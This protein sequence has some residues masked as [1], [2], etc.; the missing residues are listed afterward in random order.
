MKNEAEQGAWVWVSIGSNQDRDRSIRGA[1][2]S[3]RRR[4]GE[5]SLSRVYESNAV[6]FE[7][8][9]FFNLVVGFRTEEPVADL[10]AAFREIE[11]AF[12]R[13]RGAE[14]FCSRTL[15]ID[16]LTYGG[17]TGTLDGCSLP[18][19]EILR[20]AFVLRPLAE[21][22]GGDPHPETGQTFAD[23]WEAFE[24][25]HQPLIPVAFDFGA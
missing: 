1:V 7:G 6:G 5:L 22:A 25:H 2:G 15:D 24:R 14:K 16:L 20:Y 4:F 21:V 18:R 17:H 9:P 23:L 11:D 12:G 8:Q 19:D 3:L 13:E 10:I